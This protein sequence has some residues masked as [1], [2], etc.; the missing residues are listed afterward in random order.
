ME[1]LWNVYVHVTYYKSMKGL[2]KLKSLSILGTL[3][4]NPIPK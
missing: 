3:L 2:P 1:E 4:T